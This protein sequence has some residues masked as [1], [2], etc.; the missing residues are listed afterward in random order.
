MGSRVVVF[1]GRDYGDWATV[2]RV[3]DMINKDI[4]IDVII[5]GGYR[6]ADYMAGQWASMNDVDDY[7]FHARWKVWGKSAGPIRNQRMI[8]VGK[9]HLA[10]AFP[11]ATGTADM[12]ERVRTARIPL[13]EVAADGSV[14]GWPLPPPK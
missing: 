2:K 13:V 14:K 1:G 9:P 6:G 8:D 12:T 11:G 4:C 3:L 10:V 5:E 7:I